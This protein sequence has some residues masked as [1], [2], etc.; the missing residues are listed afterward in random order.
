[1]AS[2]LLA[3]SDMCAGRSQ[4]T[5]SLFG[6]LGLIIVALAFVMAPDAALASPGAQP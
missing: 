2:P 4:S 6:R 5:R 3:R 1:M